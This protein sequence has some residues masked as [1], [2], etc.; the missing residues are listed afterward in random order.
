MSEEALEG[1]TA[2]QA[3]AL[4]R[5]GRMSA[6]E[7]AEA[8]LAQIERLEPTIGAWAFLDRD[9]VLMQADAADDAHRSGR[10]HGPLHGIP[11]GIK[12]IV[13]TSDMPTEDGTPLHAGRRPRRDA[14]V[15][16]RLREAG[17]VIMGKTVTTELALYSPGKTANPRDPARTPGGSSSGSAAAVAASMVPLAIGSQTNGSVIRPASF[18]GVY[19]FKP[20]HGLIPR[21]GVLR[22]SRIL[23]HIGVFARSLEDIAL[24]AE[25]LVGFDE[26][27]PDTRPVARPPLVATALSEPPLPPR[28]AFAPSPVWDRAEPETQEAFAELI[29]VLGERIERLDLPGP[30]ANGVDWHRTILETDLAVNLAEDYER[31]RDMLSPSLREMIERGRRHLAFDYQRVV[32]AIPLLNRALEEAF[33]RYDAIVTPAAPGVAPVGRESTGSPVFCSLWTLC[34]LPALTLPLL[35]NEAGLPLGVQLVGAPGSDGRLL[36]TANWLAGLDLS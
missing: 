12:D 7:L 27:D 24:I 31:G 15:V 10:S 28:L 30:F 9:Y 16:A 18:C 22:L 5:D 32:N 34:G 13:D 19:G 35:Q 14:A 36:R 33:S 25:C 4:M 2:S 11:V 6:R 26:A 21:S 3:T 17:A 23:D 8:C 29:D 20:S 1:L